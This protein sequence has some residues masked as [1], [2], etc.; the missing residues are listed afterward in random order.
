M[1]RD[2]AWCRYNPS[3][4]EDLRTG[5][6]HVAPAQQHLLATATTESGAPL[7]ELGRELGKRD[8]CQAMLMSQCE[9]EEI[10]DVVRAPR[11]PLLTPV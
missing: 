5:L 7:I 3:H 9:D 10:A 6:V 8:I 1:P 4:N 11:P 2:V